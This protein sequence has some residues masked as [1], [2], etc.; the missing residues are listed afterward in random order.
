VHAGLK[1]RKLVGGIFRKLLGSVF[2]SRCGM[3]HRNVQQFVR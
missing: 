1:H 3:P 2:G